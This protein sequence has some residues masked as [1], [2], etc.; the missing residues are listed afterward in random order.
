MLPSGGFLFIYY[1]PMKWLHLWYNMY[2]V[3]PHVTNPDFNIWSILKTS[4]DEWKDQ[5]IDFIHE[6]LED[7]YITI[8]FDET[9]DGIEHRPF[10]Y[11][12][13]KDNLYTMRRRT[14]PEVLE[15][16]KDEFNI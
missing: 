1:M 4:Y 9:F 5:E 2:T 10:V 11:I 13:W 14:L 12:S 15:I 16:L 3:V 6:D 8:S 7:C